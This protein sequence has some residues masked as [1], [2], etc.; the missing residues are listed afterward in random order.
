MSDVGEVVRRAAVVRDETGNVVDA[1]ASG[2]TITLPDGT[3]EQATV[4]HVSTGTYRFDY[5]PAVQA[6]TYIYRWVFTGP[7]VVLEGS[8]YVSPPGQV[9]IIS[10]EEA[11]KLLRIGDDNDRW[12]DEIREELWT[13]TIV[14][15]RETG[16]VLVRRTITETR[17]LSRTSVARGL[18]LTWSPVVS[19][20]ALERL[21]P[22][23]VVI[24][25]A[26]APDVW[27]DEQGIVRTRR[28]L[29]H[30]LVR[31]TYVAGYAA[32]PVNYRSAVRYLLQHYW[33]NRS[34]STARPRVGGSEDAPVDPDTRT[35]LPTRV[36]ELLG[37]KTPLVG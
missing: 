22:A 32:V 30:G 23:G 25:T 33:A 2:C 3:T 31:I 1:T 26:A 5:I 27:V 10:L 18:A 4:T 6:G 19:V 16:R 20:T 7:A 34:G 17:E 21:S 24:E 14:A 28:V 12:D 13:A 9:G 11:R 35:A 8:F 29:L 15:E 37:P 36:A